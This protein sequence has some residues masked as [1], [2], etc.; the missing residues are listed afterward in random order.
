LVEGGIISDQLLRG[1]KPNREQ[2]QV[3]TYVLKSTFRLKSILKTAYSTVQQRKRKDGW[4]HFMENSKVGCGI[5][6]GFAFTP[7]LHIEALLLGTACT[8]L[9]AS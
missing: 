4:Q 7:F 8:V 6:S 3:T 2:E 5:L 9:Q 1:K